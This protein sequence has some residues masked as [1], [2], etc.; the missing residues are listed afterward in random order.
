MNYARNALG[1]RLQSFL[2]FFRAHWDHVDFSSGPT[3]RVHPGRSCGI[4][5]PIF[6]QALKLASWALKGSPSYLQTDSIVV[7]ASVRGK[8]I[9]TSSKQ[10]RRSVRAQRVSSDAFDR[11]AVNLCSAP[12]RSLR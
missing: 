8:D 2:D 3:L 1:Q 11:P 4:G 12:L 7:E 10:S 9:S 6:T 5:E